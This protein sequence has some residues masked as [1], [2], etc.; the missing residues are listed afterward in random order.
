MDSSGYVYATGPTTFK[1]PLMHLPSQAGSAVASGSTPRRPLQY[2]HHTPQDLF[3]QDPTAP[4]SV[5]TTCKVDYSCLHFPDRTPPEMVYT[6]MVPSAGY[7]G[8]HRV[9]LQPPT[10]NGSA[11]EWICSNNACLAARASASSTQTPGTAE[12]GAAAHRISPNGAGENAGPARSKRR[13]G[14]YHAGPPSGQAG[15]AHASGALGTRLESLTAVAVAAAAAHA[16]D[17]ANQAAD[18][19]ASGSST[20]ANRRDGKVAE[21]TSDGAA[22]KN[23]DVMPT[24]RTTPPRSTPTHEHGPG[25]TSAVASSAAAHGTNPIDTNTLPKTRD[26]TASTPAAA[27]AR[28]G[29]KLSTVQ[30]KITKPGPLEPAGQV[31]NLT[32]SQRVMLAPQ[33]PRSQPQP[34]RIR[35]IHMHSVHNVSH[36]THNSHSHMQD[37][38][39]AQ[40]V[41]GRPHSSQ[42]MS[43]V[44]TLV[45]VM[46]MPGQPRQV[47]LVPYQPHASFGQMPH[48]SAAQHPYHAQQSQIRHIAHHPQHG[49]AAVARHQT[50]VPAPSALYPE[51]DRMEMVRIVRTPAP[52]SASSST[53]ASASSSSGSRHH[54]KT[55]KGKAASTSGSEVPPSTKESSVSRDTTTSAKRKLSQ[56]NVDTSAVPSNLSGPSAGPS[57]GP[58]KSSVAGSAANSVLSEPAPLESSKR[59]RAS[60]PKSATSNT[61][62][63]PV[64][65]ASKDQQQHQAKRA[66]LPSLASLIAMDSF[67]SQ[68]H[69]PLVPR[70]AVTSLESTSSSRR[71]DSA[72][73]GSLPSS[74]LPTLPPCSAMATTPPSQL[75][76]SIDMSTKMAPLMASSSSSTCAEQQT[77]FRPWQQDEMQPL[78]PIS[79]PQ[80]T[81]SAAAPLAINYTTTSRTYS[82]QPISSVTLVSGSNPSSSRT[83]TRSGGRPDADVD[84]FLSSSADKADVSGSRRSSCGQHNGDDEE[85]Q[86]QRQHDGEY[87]DE[88]DDALILSTST[89]ATMLAG[90]DATGTGSDKPA[91]AVKPEVQRALK[92]KMNAEAAKR[93]RAR[94]ALQT[95]HLQTRCDALEQD[96]VDLQTRNHMLERESE[97]LR[98]REA[99]LQRRF[100]IL[101]QHVRDLERRLATAP[102]A[103]SS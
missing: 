86:R 88:D 84:V 2:L 73:S 82:E 13:Q 14:S 59:H 19:H 70:L 45:P 57:Q 23:A 37:H 95:Q 62:M 102:M 17:E 83:D 67:D 26:E 50:L 34:A 3:Q 61:S 92:R 4:S 89:C 81:P 87:D 39:Y 5:S 7:T 55:S 12:N 11:A 54:S 49:H 69:S 51:S 103:S 56:S 27:P 21:A 9:T 16:A 71:P 10:A 78:R 93:F 48:T 68:R 100:A 42:H 63:T 35:P 24:P 31:H 30:P 91:K 8:V 79:E 33:R 96:C 74:Q 76:A 41:Q 64:P 43:M 60:A 1:L 29:F 58:S 44:T 94:K 65:T 25:S 98:R 52:V 46:P 101:E 77:S 80:A 15:P 47:I 28:Q 97:T 32:H 99:D 85:R 20:T 6:V 40:P 66:T 18:T 72:G 38:E 90:H 53:A 36:E 75:P 22:V